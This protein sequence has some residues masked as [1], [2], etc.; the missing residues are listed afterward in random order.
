LFNKKFYWIGNEIYIKKFY[1]TVNLMYFYVRFDLP[2][3]AFIRM[4]FQF[5]NIWPEDI[6]N[7]W[8]GSIVVKSLDLRV[9]GRELY[10][11]PTLQGKLFNNQLFTH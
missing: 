6:L 7:L 8:L 2:N 10:L 11:L 3:E 5:C 4:D 1:N 9:S